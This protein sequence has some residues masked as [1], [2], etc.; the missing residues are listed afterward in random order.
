MANTKAKKKAAKK[1]SKIVIQASIIYY[2]DKP[3]LEKCLKSLKGKVDHILCIDGA[4]KEFPH[5]KVASTD[6]STRMAEKYTSLFIEPGKTAWKDQVEKRNAALTPV[7]KKVNYILV[8]DTDEILSGEFNLEDLKDKEDIYILPLN[9]MKDVTMIP[10]FAPRLVKV[11]KDIRYKG[12]HSLI[13]KKDK[14]IN[15]SEC[16]EKSITILTT[17]IIKHYPE[18][19]P[20]ERLAQDAEY[21]RNRKENIYTYREYAKSNAA[22]SKH[23]YPAPTSTQAHTHPVEKFNIEKIIEEKDIGLIKVKFTGK[24]YR[25]YHNGRNLRA[26]N[27]QVIKVTEKDFNDLVALWPNEW[28]RA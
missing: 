2:N 25:G 21:M 17:P 14:V 10:S 15:R 23:T 27:G 19:R 3:L 7:N 20:A 9:T 24:I 4:F 28:E 16:L 26:F 11:D 1:N 8:I 13:Y 5:T 6:G 22:S 18:N 12:K